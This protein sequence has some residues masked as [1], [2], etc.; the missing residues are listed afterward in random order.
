MTYIT[1]FLVTNTKRVSIRPDPLDTQHSVCGNSAAPVDVGGEYPELP[2]LVAEQKR[3]AF[4][5][6]VLDCRIASIKYFA[7]QKLPQDTEEAVQ[8]SIALREEI[9]SARRKVEELQLGRTLPPE[10]VAMILW[11]SLVD[12]GKVGPHPSALAK[13][14]TISFSWNCTLPAKLWNT[15]EYTFTSRTSDKFG[16][17]L[18]SLLSRGANLGLHIVFHS[19]RYEDCLVD[20][21]GFWKTVAPHTRTLTVAAPIWDNWRYSRKDPYVDFPKLQLLHMEKCSGAFLGSSAYSLKYLFGGSFPSLSRCV[22]ISCDWDEDDDPEALTEGLVLEMNTLKAL[23]L[24]GAS[25]LQQEHWLKRLTLPCLEEL[26]VQP[27]N[28]EQL[29]PFLDRSE[30]PLTTF[31]CEW[32]EPSLSVKLAGI[33]KLVLTKHTTTQGLGI[34]SLLDPAVLPNLRELNIS[35]RHPI[36]NWDVMWDVM[37]RRRETLKSITIRSHSKG[38]N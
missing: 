21:K 33:S 29:G 10:I 2:E 27:A 14:T 35:Q 22:V 17:G 28:V 32:M 34:S 8:I 12:E 11:W 38:L 5:L 19:R 4:R 31:T 7:H 16:D 20:L 9:N 24:A 26:S 18:A 37:N 30:P 23:T 15:V 6:A 3:T 25:D 1:K 13:L 36:G